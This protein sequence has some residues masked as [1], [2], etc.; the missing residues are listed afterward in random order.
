M[1][2]HSKATV[3]GTLFVFSL[4]LPARL[5]GTITASYWVVFLPIW[6]LFA[7]VLVGCIG[8]MVHWRRHGGYV[9]PDL[10][11]SLPARTL[12]LR[13]RRGLE[14]RPAAAMSRIDVTTSAWWA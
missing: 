9:P 14:R 1:R 10:R 5:D 7:A 3:F 6:I 13:R 8:A 2:A 4:V 11:L 12:T